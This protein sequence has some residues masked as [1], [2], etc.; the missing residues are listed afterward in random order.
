MILGSVEG[1][2]TVV[3]SLQGITT[4]VRVTITAP[5]IASLSINPKVSSPKGIGYQ[6]IAIATFTDGSI[7]NVTSQTTWVSLNPN[8]LSI[9]NDPITQDMLLEKVLGL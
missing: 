1:D 3:A 6:F 7:Q 5:V 4:E 9:T 2:E 8:L